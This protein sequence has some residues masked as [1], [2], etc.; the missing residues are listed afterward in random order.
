MKK[1]LHTIKRHWVLFALCVI[2]IAIGVAYIT[3]FRPGPGLTVV[4]VGNLELTNVPQGAQVYID[5]GLRGVSGGS[6]YDAALTP[7][8]H[9]VIVSVAN[10]YPWEDIVQ[11]TSNTTTKSEPLLI[12]KAVANTVIT[13]AAADSIRAIASIKPLPT[14]TTPLT[15]GCS[16][17]FIENNRVIADVATSTTGCVANPPAYLCTNG[18]CSETVVYPPIDTITGIEKYPARTDALL[19]ST[20]SH[21]YVIELDPRTPQTFAPLVAGSNIR[22]VEDTTENVFVSDDSGIHKLTF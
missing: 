20:A 4:R 7:G 12:P 11:I 8:N 1:T 6:T 10:A 17:V 5:Y 9:T 2:I 13:G 15:I 3:G 19:V 14:I 16:S 22:L 18:N 21:V